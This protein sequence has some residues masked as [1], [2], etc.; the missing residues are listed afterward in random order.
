M[1]LKRLL[2]A[3]LVLAIMSIPTWFLFGPIGGFHHQYGFGVFHY[4]LWNGE[5][6]SRT[7]LRIGNERFQVLI[8]P[9]ALG[10]SLLAWFLLLAFV[11]ACVWLAG[12]ATPASRRSAR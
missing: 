8:D 10:V 9:L 7:D 2:K 1:T 12:Q 6:P 3:C 5:D 4:M 11:V